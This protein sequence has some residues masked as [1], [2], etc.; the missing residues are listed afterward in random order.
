MRRVAR[1]LRN[2]APIAPLPFTV[3]VATWRVPKP[4][5]VLPSKALMP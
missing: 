3:V 5:A 1:S 4:V 2:C